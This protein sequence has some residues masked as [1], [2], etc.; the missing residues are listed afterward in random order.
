MLNHFHLLLKT[1][2]G[3]LSDFMR[4]FHIA[5]TSAFN[6][7][8]NRSG[9]L[10]QGRYKSFLIDADNYLNEVLRC[11]HLNPVRIKKYSKM[12]TNKKIKKLNEFRFRIVNFINYP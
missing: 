4:H 1:P 3:N 7:R 6:R 5:C 9:H 10:Y 8:H 11:I 12:D 2:H